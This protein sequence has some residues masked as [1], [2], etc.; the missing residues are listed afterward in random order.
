MSFQRL[1]NIV[2]NNFVLTL[3]K[4]SVKIKELRHKERTGTVT[5]IKLVPKIKKH[6]QLY[7]GTLLLLLWR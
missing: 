5:K 6:N 4:Q 1:N 7:F 3:F 2:V